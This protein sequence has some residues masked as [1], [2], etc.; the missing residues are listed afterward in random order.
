MSEAIIV[1]D[2]TKRFRLKHVHS[3]KEMAARAV[4][5]A[6]PEVDEFTALTDV[7]LTVTEGRPSDC[8]GST[9]PASRRC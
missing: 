4:R 7:N 6:Q 1:Q 9:D 5:R 8:S 3:L 2:V